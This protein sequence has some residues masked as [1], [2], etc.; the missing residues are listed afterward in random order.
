M[1][2]KKDLTPAFGLAIIVICL[3]IMATG[4]KADEQLTQE[5]L[6]VEQTAKRKIL[7][8][9]V[10]KLAGK[11]MSMEEVLGKENVQR[12]KEKLG[13]LPSQKVGK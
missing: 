7:E 11:N 8:E 1:K 5:K 13:L 9:Q 4:L 2:T 3:S 10:E 6:L 12:I